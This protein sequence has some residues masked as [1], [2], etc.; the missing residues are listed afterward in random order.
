MFFGIQGGCYI[1]I[2][3]TSGYTALD[4]IDIRTKAVNK[5]FYLRANLDAPFLPYS[6]EYILWL[7]KYVHFP[8]S[9]WRMNRLTLCV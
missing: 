8:I 3:T 9:E 4:E 7:Q 1:H 5:T 6:D 2:E